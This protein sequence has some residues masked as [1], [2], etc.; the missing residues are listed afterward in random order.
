M[1][2]KISDFLNYRLE[3]GDCEHVAIKLQLLTL[4]EVDKGDFESFGHYASNA[5]KRLH[6]LLCESILPD[7]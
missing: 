2:T 5:K 1:S 4:V 3:N 7:Q 6:H